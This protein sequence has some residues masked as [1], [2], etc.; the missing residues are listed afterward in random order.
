MELKNQLNQLIVN[1]TGPR[2]FKFSEY[3]KLRTEKIKK[4]KTKLIVGRANCAKRFRKILIF[5]QKMFEFLM[6]LDQGEATN[7]LRE[8]FFPLYESYKGTSL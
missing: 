4:S 2:N 3:I 6:I 5:A 1:N 8:V 7:G